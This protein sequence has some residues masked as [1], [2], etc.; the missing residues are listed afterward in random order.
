MLYEL[1][2]LRTIKAI[3]DGHST[4]DQAVRE[5]GAERPSSAA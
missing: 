2:L 3:R 1:R 4:V 5:F